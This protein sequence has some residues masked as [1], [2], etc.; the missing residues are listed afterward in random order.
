MLSDFNFADVYGQCLLVVEAYRIH[1]I[2]NCCV[3]LVAGI[4]RREQEV[5]AEI[6]RIQWLKMNRFFG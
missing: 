4:R 3:P 6:W 1:S 5:S 2:Q